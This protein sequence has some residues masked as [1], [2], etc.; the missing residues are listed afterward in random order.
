M[1]DSLGE[2]AARLEAAVE[3]LAEAAARRPR[4]APAGVPPE[5]VAALSA[6][7]EATIAR[8]RAA[9]PEGSEPEGS[10]VVEGPESDDGADDEV[11]PG[12]A[13]HGAPGGER[14]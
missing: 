1:S 9:L 7:L 5:E 11:P 14:D 4:A 10:E 6:R 8:L 3:C 13:R 12:E 2:A